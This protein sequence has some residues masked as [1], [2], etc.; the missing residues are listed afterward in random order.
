[1][2]TFEA[3][4]QDYYG[5]PWAEHIPETVLL[6]LGQALD[7]SAYAVA[8]YRHPWH[9]QFFGQRARLVTVVRRSLQAVRDRDEYQQDY[10]RHLCLTTLSCNLAG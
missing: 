10:L 6:T 3:R 2:T 8:H 4:L 1:M 7:A 5:A 9:P